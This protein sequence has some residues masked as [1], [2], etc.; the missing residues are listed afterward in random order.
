MKIEDKTFMK[1]LITLGFLNLIDAFLTLYLVT[2]GYAME[3][4][5]LMH[6]WLLM[7]DNIFLA[8]KLLVPTL[9]MYQLWRNRKHKLVYPL[10][11]MVTIVYAVICIIHFKILY[12]I[13][14]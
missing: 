2:N 6:E 7:G 14:N 5:P 10:T 9:C 11:V 12:K 3:A 1:L 8:I 4:N 13:M